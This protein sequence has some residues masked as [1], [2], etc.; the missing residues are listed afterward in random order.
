MMRGQA[1]GWARFWTHSVPQ[2]C[3]ADPGW[4]GLDRSWRPERPQ[5]RV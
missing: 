5:R 3:G 4:P 2:T 1:L